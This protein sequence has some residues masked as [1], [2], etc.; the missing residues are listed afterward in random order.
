[1]TQT[2]SSIVV[3]D[4]HP[5]FREGVALTLTQQPDF[6][7]VGQGAS[8]ADAVRL[9]DTHQP[10]LILL[11]L[12]M[13]GGGQDALVSIL[14]VAPEAKILVLTASEIDDDVLQALRA[15]ARGYVLKGVGAQA[16]VD[17]V[18]SVLAGESYV[19]PSLAARILTE[20]RVPARQP[21]G[22]GEEETD[23]DLLSHLTRREEQILRLVADGNSNK[24]VARRLDLQEKTIKHHMTSILQ[25]LKVRNRTEAAVMLKDARPR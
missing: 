12:S 7:V 8:A 13:P 4:D 20:M 5:L 14:K 9:H 22:Q 24:E 23:G 1:M 21:V 15:G 11:D 10:D 6:S 16:L 18:R 25:K 3:V 19:S 2:T 17:V